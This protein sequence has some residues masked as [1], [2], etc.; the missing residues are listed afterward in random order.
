MIARIQRWQSVPYQIYQ[1]EYL[2][3]IADFLI[4]HSSNS[5]SYKQ[6]QLG[7]PDWSPFS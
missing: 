3:V 4:K 6:I 7:H 2:T 5:V 1:D